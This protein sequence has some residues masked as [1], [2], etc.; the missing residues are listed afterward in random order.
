MV[1]FHSYLK[2]PEGN[3]LVLV[4]STDGYI[5]NSIVLSRQQEERGLT[6][7]LWGPE[8]WRMSAK[9][10]KC[11]CQLPR[12]PSLVPEPGANGKRNSTKRI[13]RHH[14]NWPCA[15][16]LRLARVQCY[17]SRQV[18]INKTWYA[19]VNENSYGKSPFSMW[20]LATKDYKR[21]FSIFSHHHISLIKS[22]GVEP[23]RMQ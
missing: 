3:W 21:P 7:S 15:I 11:M 23:T 13:S 4:S 1:S 6:N 20:K 10:R 18:W 9:C 19:L 14:M 12:I 8:T 17:N 2:L 22:P 16:P 5:V